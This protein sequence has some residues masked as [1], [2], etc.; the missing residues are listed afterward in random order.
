MTQ[1]TLN[2]PEKT[3]LQAR[4]AAAA[5]RRPVEEL[6]AEML[7]AILPSVQDAP[8]ALQAELLRMTWLDNKALWEIARSSL[9][10]ASEARLR[11]LATQV[12]LSP[13]EVEEQETLREE[14]GR[15]TLL[16]ARAYAILSLRGGQ[17]LLQ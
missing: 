2:L 10:E 11:D 7:E 14:Y 6:L 13:G 8:E 17:P 12:S 5:L 15:I 4:Q 1:I 9:S 3:V 16:K